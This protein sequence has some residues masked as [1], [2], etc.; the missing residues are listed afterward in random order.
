MPGPWN[1]WYHVIACTYGAWLPGDPRGFRTLHHREHVEGDY[2]HPPPPGRYKEHHARSQRRMN[3]EAVLLTPEQRRAACRAIGEKLVAMGVELV[4]LVVTANHFHLLARF[5]PLDPDQRRGMAIPRLSPQSTLKDG[6]DPMP[7]HVVG[8]IKKHASHKLR[9][10]GLRTQPGGLWGKRCHV[11]PIESRAH[12]LATVRYIRAH[13][14]QG[15]AVWSQ[16]DA[17]ERR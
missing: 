11:I 1:N 3:R 8:L 17:D 4:D 15:G 6:R 16:R 5:T 2:K 12:Q 14:A 7:R 13:G 9:E 10:R